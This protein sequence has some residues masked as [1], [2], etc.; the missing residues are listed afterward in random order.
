MKDI[1]APEHVEILIG[2]SGTTIWINVEGECAFRACRIDKLVL[3]DES[4]SVTK[5][6]KWCTITGSPAKKSIKNRARG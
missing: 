5:V 6:K 2:G 4:G 3:R 1:T